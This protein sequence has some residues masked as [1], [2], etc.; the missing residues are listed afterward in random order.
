MQ[1]QNVELSYALHKR[2]SKLVKEDLVVKLDKILSAQFSNNEIVRI[3]KI[4]IDL[5]NIN[6]NDLEKEFIEK[7]ISGFTEKIKS[8]NA[9]RKIDASSPEIEKIS[10]E[11]SS[12]EH[13]FYFLLTGKMP[14]ALQGINF[15]NWQADLCIVIKSNQRYFIEK[16]TETAAFQPAALERL[17]I[18]FDDFFILAVVP[19]NMPLVKADFENLF[20]AVKK[21]IPFSQMV[22]VRKK[23]L[24]A[25]LP[26][27]LNFPLTIEENKI[28]QLIENLSK[29]YPGTEEKLIISLQEKI[30]EIIKKV[31]ENF[32]PG[33]LNYT[34]AEKKINALLKEPTKNENT[35]E[36][37]NN[38]IEEKSVFIENAGLI[39]LHPFLHNLFKATGLMEE[40]SFENDFC[41]QKA[42]HLLQ[43]LVNG[44][45]QM[46]EFLMPLNKVLCGLTNQEHID[47][48]I[49]LPDAAI[50]EAGKLLDA[51][52]THWSVL[53][54]TS[55]AS[56]Q[57][58]FLQRKGKLSFNEPDG[59]WKLQ[60]ERNAVDI[61][62]D[63]VPWG[64]A[65][66]KLPWMLF[67][68]AVEW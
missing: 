64:F 30:I 3:N 10:K 65:Y 51:V 2:C 27:L 38:I 48:F 14:W 23:I 53:K 37:I 41:K 52:I 61:L 24:Q 18:Q 66:I 40:D 57:Q 20:L 26:V 54:N 56:L 4:E 7:C 29:D 49:Q 13:F 39:I 62:L 67:P 42:V 1:T 5:G 35:E 44:E 6:N 55:A 25:L 9:S 50:I 36:K 58:T 32:L 47:R 31:N 28:Q 60:V 16:L 12:I 59:Y 45:Q 22:V 11:D 63:K 46:P 8:I 21:I 43:Y 33:E 17:I 68:L 15:A 19:N 34:T